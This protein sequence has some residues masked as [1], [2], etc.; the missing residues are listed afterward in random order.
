MLQA[1]GDGDPEAAQE[2]L[3][4]VYRE[5]RNLAR[6]RLAQRPPGQTLQPTALVHEAYLRLVGRQDPGWDGR[7]HFFAAAARAMREILVEQA[8]RKAAQKRGGDRQ[9]AASELAEPVIEPPSDNVLAVDEAVRSLEE[10][11]PRKGQIVNLRFFARMTN[12]ETAEALGVSVGTIER[13][14][15]Y[16]RT[17]LRRALAAPDDA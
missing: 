16:I 1:V 15:R 3:P 14:W 12:A 5:L 17:W 8:R 2:L 6:A 9:R 10:D 13:E 7:G 11:D 4:L